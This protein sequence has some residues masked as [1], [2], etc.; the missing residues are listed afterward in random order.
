MKKIILLLT[1]LLCCGMNVKAGDYIEVDDGNYWHYGRGGSRLLGNS[2]VFRLDS[3]FFF[4]L[5]EDTVIDGKTYRRFIDNTLFIDGYSK[6]HKAEGYYEYPPIYDQIFLR[7]DNGRI[8]VNEKGYREWMSHELTSLNVNPDYMPYHTTGDGDI[9]LYDFTMKVGDK[10]ASVE[11]YDDI[12]VVAITDTITD[13]RTSRKLFTLSNGLKVIEGVG[14]INSWGMFLAYLNP[15]YENKDRGI[16]SMHE[17]MKND[18]RIYYRAWEDIEKEFYSNTVGTK[19]TVY[20]DGI[21]LEHLLTDVQKDIVTHLVIAGTPQKED[22]AFLRSDILPKLQQLD[23]KGAM[24]DTLPPNVFYYDKYVRYKEKRIVLPKVLKHCADSSLYITSSYGFDVTCEITGRFPTMGDVSANKFYDTRASALPHIVASSDNEYC[25]TIDNIIY[26]VSGD[27]AFFCGREVPIVAEGTQIIAGG[28]A[29]NSFIGEGF[30]T[31]HLPSSIDSIGDEA[32]A[33]AEVNICVGDC[34]ETYL[35]CDAVIPPKLGKDVFVCDCPGVNDSDFYYE[36]LTLSVPTESVDAYRN[37]PEWGKFK[38][39]VNYHSWIDDIEDVES[40]SIEVADCGDAYVLS[41]DKKIFYVE[42]YGIDGR[43]LHSFS[44][45]GNNVKIEKRH[46]TS[47]YAIVRVCCED[48]TKKY[49]KL[50]R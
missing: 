40:P 38:K 41:F 49:V 35:R 3:E 1:V 18:D 21:W 26:S 29:S 19:F 9:I 30:V 24:I 31:I 44:V 13:G 28:F 12:S 37:H 6:P 43:L 10:F 32:F 7:E 23:L 15:K 14:C 11:G 5:C 48:K 46:L 16:V 17:C 2:E 33:G 50:H 45:D 34:G 22:Y 8:L 39:I 27:T 47:P 20:L 36:F 42:V 25:K 4:Y